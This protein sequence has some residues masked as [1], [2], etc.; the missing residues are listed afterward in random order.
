MNMRRFC[1]AMAVCIAIPTT[2]SRAAAQAA[3]DRVF[4]MVRLAPDVYVADVVARPPVY[5]FANSLVVIGGDGVLV[6]DTQQSPS[7]ARA[8]IT[9]IRRLT[10][11]PV[12]WV[13]NTHGHADHVAGNVAYRATFPDVAFIAHESLAED[14]IAENESW[15]REQIETL[16]ATIDDR[17]RWLRE[18]RGPDGDPLSDEDRA[19]IRYSLRLR[20]AYLDELRGL[21]FVRPT[22][23]FERRMEID[24]GGRT[25]RLMHFGRAHTRGDVVVHL[26]DEGVLAV[27]DLLEH[28]FPWVEGADPAGWAAALDAVAKLDASTYVPGHGPVVRDRTLL[29]DYRALLATVAA[30]AQAAECADRPAADPATL[31][32]GLPAGF[33]E[34]YGLSPERVEDG[35][36]RALDRAREEVDADDC[37]AG[38]SSAAR[39]SLSRP[40]DS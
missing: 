24:V 37:G 10:D 31:A 15:R 13:V 19:A 16:P 11:T 28:G 9:R 36:R 33:A 8:L 7:A 6:V 18:G 26:P 27:G 5:A 22:R 21:E 12:R 30:E 20:D 25:V 29:R 32:T 35:L 14:V 39:G 4:D 1:L 3:A 38:R 40:R 2:R 34:R 23:T 17:R